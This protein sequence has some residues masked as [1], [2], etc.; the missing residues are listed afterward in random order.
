LQF[1]TG[2]PLSLRSIRGLSLLETVFATAVLV[3][4]LAGVAQLVASSAR[5]LLD[6][7]RGETALT[8]A[9]AQ[10]ESLRS[11]VFSYDA[12]GTP[13][14]DP[15][16]APSPPGALDADTSGY[17]DYLD[18]RGRPVDPIVETPMFRRRW[19]LAPIDGGEPDALV[20]E[21]C[22]W[23]ISDGARSAADAEACLMT[24][25]ARQP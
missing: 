10:I 13:I 24:V 22:V 23:S 19:S 6:A 18:R 17:I 16:L 5:F 14:S 15:A 8:A 25:R 4:V 12:G 1:F 9:Q 7:G 20:I 3:T 2:M 11:R 21:V